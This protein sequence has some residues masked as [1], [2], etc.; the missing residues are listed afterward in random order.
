MTTQKKENKATKK[1][2]SLVVNRLIQDRDIAYI[3]RQS[4]EWERRFTELVHSTRHGNHPQ[5]KTLLLIA[6][7][8]KKGFCDERSIEEIVQWLQSYDG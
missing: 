6:E 2:G 5:R 7:S 8:Y 3:I 4:Y 1:A